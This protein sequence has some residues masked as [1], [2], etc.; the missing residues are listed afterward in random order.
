MLKCYFH[1][2]ESKSDSNEQG[3]NNMSPGLQTEKTSEEQTVNNAG[4]HQSI[5]L[6]TDV[7]NSEPVVHG[8][9]EQ[10]AA[11][12][13]VIEDNS[14]EEESLPMASGN[15][16]SREFRECEQFY[17]KAFVH[18]VLS[19]I[20]CTVLTKDSRLQKTCVFP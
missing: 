5:Q 10:A 12:S 6:Q 18:Y 1:R 13:C 3:R 7:A 19:R 4:S 2:Y 14:L 9:L 11:V 8:V 20:T 16:R 17:F 15:L